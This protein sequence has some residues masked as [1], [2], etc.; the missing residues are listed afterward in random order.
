M[1]DVDPAPG[2]PP[3]TPPAGGAPPA[4]TPPAGD[5]P[6][7]PAASGLESLPEWA[8]KE[9]KTVRAEAAAARL[10]L[11]GIEDAQLSEQEKLTKRAQEL[12]QTATQ[13]DNELRQ[14]RAEREV[15]RTAR[16]LNIVDEETALALVRSK[17]EFDDAGK[18]TNVTK[19]LEQLVKDKP[20]L[21]GQGAPPPAGNPG[22][23]AGGRGSALTIEAIKSMT[24]EQINARWD[25]VQ[26]A[27]K[28]GK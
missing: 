17:I 6:A 16:R 2:A 23:P 7:P 13:R 3:A 27:I 19:L 4:S 20:F 1:A 11:K 5:P 15:E 28:A 24:R 22:N 12:E 14:E 8:Q 10:K 25:D 9:L 21:I 26:A 18:P